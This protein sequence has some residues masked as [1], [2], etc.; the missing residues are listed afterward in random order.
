[1]SN[2]SPSDLPQNNSNSILRFL[3]QRHIGEGKLV[4]LVALFLLV[5][6]NGSFY[7]HVLHD[8]PLSASNILPLGSLVVVLFAVLM[9]LFTLCASR[10]ST[11]FVLVAL[12]ISA[13][14]ASHYMDTYNIVIDSEMYEN[15]FKTSAHEAEDVL[16][17]KL[18]ITIV[19]WGILPSI[20]I[21]SRKVNYFNFKALW[22]WKGKIILS[23]LLLV[24]LQ[25]LCF[26]KFYASFLREHKALRTYTNPTF[27]VYSGFKYGSSFFKGKA[28]SHQN[29]GL[30][31]KPSAAQKRKNLVI[32][33][34]GET[35]RADH[36]SL[37]GYARETNPLLAKEN[38]INFPNF[39]SSFT[40]T[41]QSLPCMFASFAADEFDRNRAD[42]TD[43]LLDLLQRAG[44][45]V[46]WRENNTGSQHVADRV[47]FQDY[48]R[49]DINPICDIE[50]R[51]EGML[52]GLQ[53]YIN[54][55]EQQSIFIVLHQMGNHGPAYYK[56]Y[57]KAFEKFTPVQKTQ[58]LEECSIEE[59]VNAYDNAILYTDYFLAKV[60]A[61]L[62][63]ES[64]EFS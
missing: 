50:P 12:T 3:T 48:S 14:S 46:I 22:L 42:K 39:T 41:A 52:V 58:Q 17:L 55:H 5:F 63:L 24:G 56:R 31:A 53:D 11:K 23:M 60:I 62:K 45:A 47:L 19:V 33:V 38:I 59:I 13:A 15:I 64:R 36:F 27:L 8:Y 28:M 30:D 4:V 2:T 10:W 25:L 34:A 49:E 7:R 26:S 6:A 29:I 32:F 18:L 44:V 1:M 43:N 57:P 40:S 61:L 21:L 16:S 9:L 54:E 20:W 37:N 51:D 35:A